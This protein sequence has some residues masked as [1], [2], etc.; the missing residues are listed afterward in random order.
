MSTGAVP[1]SMSAGVETLSSDAEGW[2]LSTPAEGETRSYE[3]TVSFELAFASTPVVHLGIAGFDVSNE[4]TAR[5]S[6]RAVEI[7]PGGFTIVVET[8]AGSRVFRADVSWLA[9]GH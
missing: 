9:L 8:W 1:L 7:H 2:T 3:K 6:T 5:L 4:D